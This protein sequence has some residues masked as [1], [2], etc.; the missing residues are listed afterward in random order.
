MATC[1]DCNSTVDDSAKFCPNCG[2]GL[3][4]AQV[5]DS[6]SQNPLAGDPIPASSSQRNKLLA[7]GALLVVAGLLLILVIAPQFTEFQRLFFNYGVRQY[8]PEYWM[9]MV[10]GGVCLLLGG[11]F[12]LKAIT[13]FDKGRELRGQ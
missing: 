1:P 11:A 7:Y 4:I 10:G 6:A 8:D 13:S 12:L 3:G 9:A 2:N 5:V